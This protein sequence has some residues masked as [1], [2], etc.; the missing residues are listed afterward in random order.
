MVRKATQ[1]EVDRQHDLALAMPVELDGDVV[2]RHAGGH[3]MTSTLWMLDLKGP[4]DNKTRV[5]LRFG[6]AGTRIATL[7]D[8][9]F[10]GGSGAPDRKLAMWSIDLHDLER[11]KLTAQRNRK[12]YDD[13]D[14]DDRQR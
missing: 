5:H 1:G 8:G 4:A 9:R 10:V 14:K 13:R 3:V 11:L 6:I 12:A 2:V 7:S